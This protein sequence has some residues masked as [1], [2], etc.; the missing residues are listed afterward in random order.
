MDN[1]RDAPF[2][3][4]VAGLR[5]GALDLCAASLRYF[6]PD[7]SFAAAVLETIGRPL[8]KPLRA[9]SYTAGSIHAQVILAW[10]SPTE[11][12]LLCSERT[13]MA[14]FERRLLSLADGC[15][16]DQSGG[17]CVFQ[18]QGGRARDLLQR[19]GAT[20]A[21]PNLSEACAARFAELPMLT[22]CV[23]ADE[24]LLIV[25][26]VYADHLMEWIRATAADFD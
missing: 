12:L 14:E 2:A 25:E 17:V 13:V 24:F 10:R 8:P 18:A 11:T 5:V 22:V 16:V 26:R 6:D 19:M 4:E 9:A 20:T 1:S 3:V 15:M 21:I 7:G 23:K